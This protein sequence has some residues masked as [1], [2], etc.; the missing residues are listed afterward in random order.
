MLVSTI[1]PNAGQLNTIGALGVDTSDFTGFD[2]FTLA[3]VNTAYASLTT[4]GGGAGLYTINLATGAATLIGAINGQ[5]LDGLAVA[6]VAVPEPTTLAL[7]ALGGIAAVGIR[8]RRP[9]TE[10]LLRDTPIQN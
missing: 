1:N 5:A 4:A 2:I 9:K 7:L 3:G 6:P 8:R 10:P